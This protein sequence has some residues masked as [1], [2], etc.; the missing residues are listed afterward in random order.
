MNPSTTPLPLRPLFAATVL[1]LL[2]AMPTEV[3]A[4]NALKIDL[5]AGNNLSTVDRTWT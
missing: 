4:V 2:V 5:T 1:A 3:N